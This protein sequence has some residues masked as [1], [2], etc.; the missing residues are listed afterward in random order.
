MKHKI[1][2]LAAFGLC[3]TS[4]FAHANYGLSIDG[5]N[6]NISNCYDQA[7]RALEQKEGQLLSVASCRKVLHNNWSSNVVKANA[8]HNRGLIYQHQGKVDKAIRDFQRAIKLNPQSKTTQIALAQLFEDKQEYNLAL[9]HYELALEQYEDN[10]ILMSKIE[11]LNLVL[12]S[13]NKHDMVMKI[14]KND[15]QTHLNDE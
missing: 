6:R 14:Q 7:Q 15:P 1:F 2:I 3:I 10:R 11:N 8:F 13:L 12:S 5:L 9:I 4:G